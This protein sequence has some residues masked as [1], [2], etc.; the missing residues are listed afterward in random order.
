MI[1]KVSSLS[2]GNHKISFEKNVK[3]LGLK[4]PFVDDLI[5]NCRIDKSD[6][7]IILSCE[8]TVQANF[9]CDRC[10]T[11][12]HQTLYNDFQLVYFFDKESVDENNLNIRYLPEAETEIDL[13]KDAFEYTQCAVPMKKLC[14][15]NCKGLCSSC[16]INLNEKTC[17][18][19]N[20]E[21]NPVWEKLL[22]LKDK[23]N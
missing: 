18:C 9:I 17:N 7:Q 22:E 15:E 1:I 5:L 2:N 20:E 12:F 21:I 13:T 8:V 10:T 4:Q 6:H 14:D 3:E 11:N 16:G 19:T 23:L